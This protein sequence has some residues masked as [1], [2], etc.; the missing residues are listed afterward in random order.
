MTAL[1]WPVLAFVAG[2]LPFSVWV[3]RL[4]LHT[5][6]RVYGDSNPGATNVLR[7]G[8]WAWGALALLLDYLKGAIPVGLA[9]FWAGVEDWLLVVVALAPA[10]GASPAVDFVDGSY[11]ATIGFS[12]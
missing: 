3:G 10:A 6:I 8:G 5:D 9:Y 7:A 1:V 2:A 11:G 12:T 4:A